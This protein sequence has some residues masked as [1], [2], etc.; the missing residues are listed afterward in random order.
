VQE[1]DKKVALHSSHKQ[2]S[3]YVLSPFGGSLVAL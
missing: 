2:N 3:K 1:S